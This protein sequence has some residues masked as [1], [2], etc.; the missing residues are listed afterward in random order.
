MEHMGFGD[1]LV[2]LA[3][4]SPNWLLRRFL[5]RSAWLFLLATEA[6][7]LF[8]NA[9]PFP[10]LAFLRQFAPAS[11]RMSYGLSFHFHCRFHFHF[12]LGDHA[13]VLSSL[14]RFFHGLLRSPWA[15]STA[16]L[17]DTCLDVNSAKSIDCSCPTSSSSPAHFLSGGA[18]RL[19][20]HK[21]NVINL[22]Q[23]VA[24]ATKKKL[25]LFDAFV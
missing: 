21:F 7:C 14:T 25:C 22:A 3:R 24:L 9:L 10:F 13:E 17:G 12:L 8:L 19:A 6:N 1:F 5:L 2:S 16:P 15:S 23:G 4:S 18:A 20:A 11:C